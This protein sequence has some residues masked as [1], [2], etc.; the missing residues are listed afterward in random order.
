M[1]DSTGRDHKEMMEMTILIW[2]HTLFYKISKVILVKVSSEF[3][4]ST[5]NNHVI[6]ISVYFTNNKFLN[7]VWQHL[8][9]RDIIIGFLL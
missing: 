7:L 8:L 5:Q 9:V 1:S 3:F 6:E 4:N 2:I